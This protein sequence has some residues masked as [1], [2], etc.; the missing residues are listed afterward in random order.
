MKWNQA[1]YL[2]RAVLLECS[3]FGDKCMKR[4]K[5]LYL[6]AIFAWLLAAAGGCFPADAQ[7]FA[8][9]ANAHSND[10]SAYK[11]DIT[12]G[13]L[14]PVSGSPFAAGSAPFSVAVDPSGKPAT[15]AADNGSAGRERLWDSPRNCL[16]RASY[17]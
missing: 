15:G 14:S 17:R 12:T 7:S 6:V 5:R 1:N 9:V 10:V 3:Q 13:A 4:S 11:I 2:V 8:Y 16:S